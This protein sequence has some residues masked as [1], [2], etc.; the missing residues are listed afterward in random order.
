MGAG[1]GACG[2]MLVL[3]SVLMLEVVFALVLVL[4]HAFVLYFV[5]HPHPLYSNREEQCNDLGATPYA[6]CRRCP[7][8]WT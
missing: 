5:R 3:G 2:L 6:R 1:V 7:L 8:F 4:R